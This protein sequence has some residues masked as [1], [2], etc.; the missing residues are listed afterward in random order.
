[1]KETPRSLALYFGL[2]GVFGLLGSVAS[3]GGILASPQA[4]SPLSMLVL[5]FL[6]GGTVVN[7]AYFYCAIK[8]KELLATKPHLLLRLSTLGIAMSLLSFNPFTVAINIYIY[9]QLK[10][11]ASEATQVTEDRTL[12]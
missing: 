8:M 10:R 1:M 7:L 11:M 6:A 5:L 2:V 12:V 9:Y 3:L 4:R